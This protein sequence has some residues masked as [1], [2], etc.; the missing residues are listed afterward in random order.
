MAE[1]PSEPGGALSGRGE[2]TGGAAPAGRAEPGG[3][4]GRA[5]QAGR[6]GRAEDGGVARTLFWGTPEFALPSLKTLLDGGAPGCAVAGV[7]TRPPRPKGRGRKTSRSPVAEYAAAKGVPVL[8]PEDPNAPEFVAELDRMAPDLSVVVAYGRILSSA[9]LD[10]P[11]LGSFNLHASLLPALRGAAPVAW[12]IANGDAE[13]GATVMRMAR[14]MD[15]GPIVSQRRMEIRETDTGTELAARLAEAGAQ[16]LAE[17]IGRITGGAAEETE[18]DHAAATYAP[19]L[20]REA[21]RIDWS[22]PAPDVVNLVRAMDAVPGAW[23]MLRGAPLKLFRP[24][25]AKGREAPGVVLAADPRAGLVVAA[26]DGAVR[27]GQVQPPGKRRM[28][29]AAW[30]AGRSAEP[31]DR[32]A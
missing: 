23:T 30:T 21:A 15:A 5:R 8:A 9:A 32:C 26:G 13:T 16:L 27:F 25:A 6:A 4:I 17:T 29:S 18:Q 3:P 10:V 7:V 22:R 28:A 19:K 12:A 24:A 20:T 2:P 11:R 14:A 31:G 1:E